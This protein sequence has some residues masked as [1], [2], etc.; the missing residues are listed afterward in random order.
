MMKYLA[1]LLLL[2]A[3]N[4]FTY[5]WGTA[6]DQLAQIY[7]GGSMQCGYVAEDELDICHEHVSWHLC[8]PDGTCDAELDQGVAEKALTACDAAVRALDGDGCYFLGYWGVMPPEC[9]AV[10]D[11][12]PIL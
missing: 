10:F 8:A 2:T 1:A 6:S 5:T 11:L 4:D 3:C 12:E 9:G 7:C